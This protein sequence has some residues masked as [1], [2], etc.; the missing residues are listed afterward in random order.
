MPVVA[1]AVEPAEP[2]SADLLP[3]PHTTSSSSITFP[4]G[5]PQTQTYPPCAVS[6]LTSSHAQLSTG[7]RGNTKLL[8]LLMPVH[9]ATLIHAH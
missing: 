4:L 5:L 7:L 2:G 6:A 9:S 3:I 8:L 1:G